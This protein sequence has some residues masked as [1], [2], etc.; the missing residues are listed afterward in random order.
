MQLEGDRAVTVRGLA[1]K[2]PQ[3]I[4]DEHRLGRTFLPGE[5]QERNGRNLIRKDSPKQS[6]IRWS[7]QGWVIQLCGKRRHQITQ[8]I[9]TS[10]RIIISTQPDH[11]STKETLGRLNIPTNQVSFSS[12]LGIKASFPTHPTPA[13]TGG[14]RRARK[15]ASERKS[16]V[17]QNIQDNPRQR[18]KKE[19]LDYER[20]SA[21]DEGCQHKSGARKKLPSQQH[22]CDWNIT[23]PLSFEDQRN[24]R[25]NH[26]TLPKTVDLR[27]TGATIQ[28]ER[29]HQW[30]E[31]L[32]LRVARLTVVS[33][34]VPHAW[35]AKAHCV[36]SQ[37]H[38]STLISAGF[39]THSN[40]RRSRAAW[41]G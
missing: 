2:I 12:H 4:D 31:I 27:A 41:I 23:R 36:P 10:F 7:E 39:S 30:W 25:T 29:C 24:N 32:C 21:K 26:R 37:H 28:T 35:R 13:A 40:A 38:S 19:W 16:A 8:T 3:Q 15:Q 11:K 5:K 14:G 22:R 9:L 1:V 6:Q 33:C 17:G 20:S 34:L 18:K